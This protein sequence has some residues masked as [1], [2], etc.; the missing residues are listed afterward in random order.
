MSNLSRRKGAR[1]E[2]D[3]AHK[4]NQLCLPLREA[5]LATC[6]KRSALRYRLVHTTF[7][8]V[9]EVHDARIDE[10]QYLCADDSDNALRGID[11]E[12]GIGQPA[13]GQRTTT[14]SRT[15]L[16]VDQEA[17]A[18]LEIIPWKRGRSIHRQLGPQHQRD[19]LMGQRG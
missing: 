18:P 5:D 15:L 14:T 1:I 12:I 10:A 8:L 3:V 19:A 11:P 9:V 13:P 17:Q 6:R 2:N 16:R 7:E 4:L